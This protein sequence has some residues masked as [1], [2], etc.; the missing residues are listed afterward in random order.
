MDIWLI[1]KDLR[2]NRDAHLEDD[3]TTSFELKSEVRP[4]N[5]KKGK[6][7]KAANNRVFLRIKFYC[8]D[9]DISFRE[10]KSRSKVEF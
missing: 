10:R 7:R 4:Q 3:A 1:C 5:L 8:P 2:G 9:I 6:K